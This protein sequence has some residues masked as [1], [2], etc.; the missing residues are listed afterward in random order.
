MDPAA[1]RLAPLLDRMVDYERLRP[2]QR[3]WDLS[4]VERLLR[5]HGAPVPVRPAIQ[6][7][8]SKGKG[9]TA[10][11]LEAL[12]TAAGLR[13]G[14]YSSPHLMTLCERIRI[15]GEPIRVERLEPVLAGL[16]DFAGDQPPTFF[17]AM[18]VAAVA[19]FA[20]DQ[21]GLAI[22]EVGLGGRFDATTAI[23]VDAAIVTRIELEHT[24]VLGDTIAAIAAEKAAV[25]RPGGLGLTATTG[26][27]LAVIRAHAEK[28]AAE[29][30]VMGEDF[31]V[32]H[33]NWTDD[34]ARG[35]LSL[36]DGSRQQFF[37]PDA[38]AFE[39]PALA[40]AVA[41][42]SRLYPDLT[43][44][45]DPVPRPYL[46]CRFEVRTEPDGEVLILDGA[47]TEDSMQAVAAE[48]QRRYPGTTPRV[49]TAWATGKRWQEALSAVHVIADSFVVTEL[50]G[51][52]GE[53]P[54]TISAWLTEQG[55]QSEVATDVASGLRKL[56]DYPGPRLVVGSFYLAGAVRQLLDSDA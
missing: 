39:L 9:T 11:F 2:M 3:E 6:V 35:L 27:A 23:D 51:T 5:R 55:A 52:P 13:T 32:H 41:T 15:A 29:L 14:S 30:L 50:T 20:Q 53:D 33:V 24:D 21:V 37:L 1:N 56:R 40:L 16:L 4:G 38:K 28:V 49:L 25:I 26:D 10:A 43:L 17:E 46:P 45:L 47:H 7:A 48:V 54:A 36:P 42:L 22:Y 12:G 8:G 18:T 31:G 34:G 19:C 44:P